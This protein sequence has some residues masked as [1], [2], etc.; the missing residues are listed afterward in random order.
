MWMGTR[1]NKIKVHVDLGEVN[2]PQKLGKLN[3]FTNFKY[4]DGDTIFRLGAF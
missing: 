3:L 4:G 1:D 2:M